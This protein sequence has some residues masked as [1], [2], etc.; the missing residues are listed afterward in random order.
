[1]HAGPLTPYPALPPLDPLLSMLAWPPQII[2]YWNVPP[3][4]RKALGIKDGLIRFACGVEETEDILADVAQALEVLEVDKQYLKDSHDVRRSFP[5]ACT[6]FPPLPCDI[7]PSDRRIVRLLMDRCAPRPSAACRL[8]VRRRGASRNSSL[9]STCA[10]FTAPGALRRRG[11]HRID[12]RLHPYEIGT[13]ARSHLIA[14]WVR[15]TYGATL[16]H[17]GSRTQKLLAHH[18]HCLVT[19]EY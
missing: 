8:G 18:H 5:A 19:R 1:V 14:K 4:E 10:F 7:A 16:I 3:E 11:A 12:T 6:S 13:G 9:Y 2:S 17:T 15:V